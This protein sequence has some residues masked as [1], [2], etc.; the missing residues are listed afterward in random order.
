M[1]PHDFF[2][3]FFIHST[4]FFHQFFFSIHDGKWKYIKNK[5]MMMKKSWWYFSVKF[6]YFINTWIPHTRNTLTPPNTWF[7]LWV[8]IKTISIPYKTNLIA[9]SISSIY[10]LPYHN[11]FLI[12]FFLS[13]CGKKGWKHY[14]FDGICNWYWNLKQ[15][16]DMQTLIKRWNNFFFQ[17]HWFCESIFFIFSEDIINI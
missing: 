10:Q 16:S 2:S 14:A 5:M 6:F 15:T 1:F 7:V 4:F 13:I 3:V 8:K 9:F 17:R 11:Q 12:L